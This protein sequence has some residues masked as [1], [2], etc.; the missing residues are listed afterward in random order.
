LLQYPRKRILDD[1]SS[2]SHKRAASREPES[3]KQRYQ[4][5]GDEDERY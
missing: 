2:S 4:E 3:G 5:S 1:L